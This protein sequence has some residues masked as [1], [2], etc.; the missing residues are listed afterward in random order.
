M[1]YIFCALRCEARPFVEIYKLKKDSTINYL[2]VYRN[3]DTTIVVC[4]I[5]KS[6][7]SFAIGCM[8]REIAQA[9]SASL[10]AVCL[11]FGCAGSYSQ[12]HKV[13]SLFL[14]NSIEDKATARHFYPDSIIRSELLEAG[15][16][17]HDLPVKILL[18]KEILVDM[19]ASSFASAIQ[20]ILVPSRWAVIKIISDIVGQDNFDS[21]TLET[22][23]HK[24]A[25][26]VISYLSILQELAKQTSSKTPMLSELEIKLIEELALGLRLSYQMKSQLQNKSLSFKARGFDLEALLKEYSNTKVSARIDGKHLFAEIEAKLSTISY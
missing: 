14:I 9:D 22:N 7:M 1:K 21:A 13:G 17:T 11:N 24:V 10:N 5:G 3:A 26:N 12:K 23:I 6:A 2:E 16:E 20:K 18:E 19:E 4:G 15:I 25:K 8:A